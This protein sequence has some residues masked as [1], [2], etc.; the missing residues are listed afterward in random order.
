MWSM[1]KIILSDLFNLG[2][3]IKTQSSL[4]MSERKLII[5]TNES[6]YPFST[7]ML[8]TKELNRLIHLIQISNGLQILELTIL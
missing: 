2:G 3:K 5:T 7:V 1:N 8:L 4:L 6:S